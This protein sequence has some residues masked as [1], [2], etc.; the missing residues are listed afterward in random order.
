MYVMVW[1]Q[2][3]IYNYYFAEIHL[4]TVLI[5]LAE[6]LFAFS[7][8]KPEKWTAESCLVS[9]QSSFHVFV[10]STLKTQLPRTHYLNTF[11]LGITP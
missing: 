4:K 8:A 2:M 10:L 7:E 11:Y 5:A 3:E 1:H 9:L 6:K